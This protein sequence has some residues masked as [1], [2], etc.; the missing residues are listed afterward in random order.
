MYIV[1]WLKSWVGH[2]PPNYSCRG[3][4]H[5]DLYLNTRGE[6]ELHQSV[7]GLRSRRVDVDDALEGAEL[8]LLTSL[9]V[10]EGRAVYSENLLL[11]GQGYRTANH[12]VSASYGLNDL[13]CRLI[14]QVVVERLKLNSNF[15]IQIVS[16]IILNPYVY[17]PTSR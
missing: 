4:S 10:N 1:V 12:S 5:L 11:C 15:L 13:L 9:L 7:D 2:C 3:L 14:N 16:C 6:L 8:E 17:R